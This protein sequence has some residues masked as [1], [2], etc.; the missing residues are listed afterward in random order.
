EPVLERLG[1]PVTI[2]LCTGIVGTRRGFWFKHVERPAALKGLPDEERLERQRAEGFD[3][4]RELGESEGL[5]RAEIE[6]L[7]RLVDFQSHT[8][9]HPIL[10]RCDDAK[11]R[12]EICGAREAL[13]G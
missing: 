4:E 3:E 10:P 5:T 1:V 8:V 12:A 7:K 6:Q 11:A 2:F 13:V 9:S